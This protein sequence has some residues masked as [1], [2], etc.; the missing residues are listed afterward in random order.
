M[1][2]LG[3]LFESDYKDQGSV[4]V[5]RVAKRVAANLLGDR[6]NPLQRGGANG[7]STGYDKFNRDA[8]MSRFGSMVAPQLIRLSHQP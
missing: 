7:E 6:G 4:N 8:G 3:I 1:S 5:L 2:T